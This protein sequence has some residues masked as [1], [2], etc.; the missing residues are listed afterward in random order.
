MQIK[1]SEIADIGNVPC[2]KEYGRQSAR[3]I[4][5]KSGWDQS[6]L[7]SLKVRV[8]EIIVDT[9]DCRDMMSSRT[10]A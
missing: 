8:P 6:T 2:T 7:S 9:I 10:A 5:Q 4:R 3:P 1:L